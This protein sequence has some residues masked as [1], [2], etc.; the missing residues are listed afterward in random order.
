MMGGVLASGVT[1]H[2]SSPLDKAVCI[3]PAARGDNGG[4]LAVSVNE[5]MGIKIIVYVTNNDQYSK[6]YFLIHHVQ[7]KLY[8]NIA[9]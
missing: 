4:L 9:Q 5:D 6:E 1:V 2:P 3:L 7:C 8:K